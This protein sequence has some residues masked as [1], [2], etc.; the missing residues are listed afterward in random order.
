MYSGRF[1]ALTVAFTGSGLLDDCGR[2]PKHEA[3]SFP[4]NMQIQY[5]SIILYGVRDFISVSKTE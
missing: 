4:G 2:C 1:S 5:F 3:K